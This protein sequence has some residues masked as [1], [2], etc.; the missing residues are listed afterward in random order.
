MI[1]KT[2][3]QNASDATLANEIVSSYEEIE[4]NFVSKNWKV[5]ELDAGHFVEAV[6]RFIE[7]KLFGSYTPIGTSLQSFN[8]SILRS[9]ENGTGD[10]SYRILI[11]RTL[12]SVYAIRNKR[13][14][15]HIGLVKPNQ[16]DATLIFQSVKWTL[17][18]LIRLNSTIVMNETDKLISQITQRQLDILWKQDGITRILNKNMRID[19]KVL[20]L[21]YD[22]SP[23]RKEQLQANTKYKDKSA[24]KKVLAKLD[25]DLFIEYKK[26]ES[27][28]I[29]P[30][31][32]N[33][34]EK[35]ILNA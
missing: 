8:D 26:D 9:Y 1:I 20:I 7:F 31:G 2:I 28:H 16:I 5:T 4:K 6:R 24:F 35:I 32:V 10:E 29:T 13:G 18:E 21:L 23:Q 25:S 14:V 33:E 22:T 19:K 3:L 27:C 17:A 30:L 11:P 12:Y 15:G 34:A